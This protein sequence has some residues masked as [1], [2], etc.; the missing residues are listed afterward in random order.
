MEYKRDPLA[1]SFSFRRL[2]GVLRDNRN[3]R[4]LYAANAVSQLGDWFNVVALFS[5]LLELTGKGEAVA[6]ALLTRFVPMFLAG[7]AAGIVADRLSRRAIMIVSDVLRA[8]LVLCLLFIRRPDQAWIAYGVVTAHSLVSAFFEPAQQA[9]L[10]NLVSEADYPLAATLEN[11]LWAATLA[12]G[13]ALGGVALAVVGRD[14]AFAADAASFLV[15]A[16]LIARLPSGYANR[17]DRQAM[18]M[19]EEAR[20]PGSQIENLLGVRDLRE[21]VAYVRSHRRVRALLAVKA[22]FGLTLGGVLV[23]LAWFG[24]KVFAQG[25]GAGIAILWTARGVGSFAGPFAAFRIS[26][27]DERGLR[28]GISGA[29]ALLAICY[30]GFALSSAIGYAAIALAVANAGGSILWTS[31]S[32]LLQRIVPD[33]VRGR[34]AAAE[35]GGFMLALSASTLATGLLLDRDVSP[36]ALMAG[37]GLIAL[38]P[39]AYWGFAQRAFEVTGQ[40]A[41]G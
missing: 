39:L 21:G 28:R 41:R 37:C 29:F 19:V 5:L 17:A 11:S 15:S 12:V 20:A 6:F 8:G 18:E 25:N 1:A 14:L 26:G 4:T 13:S 3:F 2:A 30:V 40:G 33:A 16:A 32:T 9:M 35:I 36:R 22:S 27:T 7:P 24:E 31:G 38:V 34:V 23:L 10:P